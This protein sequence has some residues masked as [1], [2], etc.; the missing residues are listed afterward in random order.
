V[1]GVKAWVYLGE[2]A[3]PAKEAGDGD[4]A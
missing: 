1:T 2:Y 3:Q 4:D